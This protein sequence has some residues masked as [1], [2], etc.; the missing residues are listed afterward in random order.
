M[1]KTVT[2]IDCPKEWESTNDWDS[3]RELLYLSLVNTKGAVLEFGAGLGST[4][5]IEQYCKE[6]G[7]TFLSYETNPQWY[8]KVKSPHVFLRKNYEEIVFD[9]KE[10]VGLIFI[11]AAPAEV[12]KYMIGEY[13]NKGRVIVVH[14]S[15]EGANYVYDMKGV[16]S[17]FI[18]RLDYNP[19]GKPHTTA[20]SNFIDVTTWI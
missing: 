11:D 4:P 16:L 15:E 3:H 20:V 2:H 5:L 10:D 12:R 13:A 1:T 6:S 9:L 18:Y 19:K 7:R 14:D 8:D 17:N